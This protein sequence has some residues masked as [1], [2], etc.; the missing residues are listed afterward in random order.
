MILFNALI[1]HCHFFGHFI[2][3][4]PIVYLKKISSSQLYRFEQTIDWARLERNLTFLVSSRNSFT[5]TSTLTY[6]RYI[7]FISLLFC[8][9]R[10]ITCIGNISADTKQH[11]KQLVSNQHCLFQSD[12]IECKVKRDRMHDLKF[13][14]AIT[15]KTNPFEF[16]ILMS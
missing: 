2:D 4:Y 11:L 12:S 14:S 16:F 6:F 15:A 3:F 10:H 8:T 9:F 13:Q 1:D 7:F 5:S